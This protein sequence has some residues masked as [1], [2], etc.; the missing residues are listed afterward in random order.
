LCFW[1]HDHYLKFKVSNGLM[2][3]GD[4]LLS[5]HSKNSIHEGQSIQSIV[6]SPEP[7]SRSSSA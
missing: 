3:F 1:Y 5:L 2:S 6:R 7:L 4:R